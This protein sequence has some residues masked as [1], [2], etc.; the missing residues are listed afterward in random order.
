MNDLIMHM[1]GTINYVDMLA[2]FLSN[3][4]LPAALN[5]IIGERVQVGFDLTTLLSNAGPNDFFG[6][7]MKLSNVFATR[8]EW[9]E[10][11]PGRWTVPGIS[12]LTIREDMR[13]AI[14]RGCRMIGLSNIHQFASIDI[15][16][17]HLGI[18]LGVI[19]PDR[20]PILWNIFTLGLN[21]WEEAKKY[22][23]PNIPYYKRDLKAAFYAVLNGGSASRDGVKRH[24]TKSHENQKVEVSPD[25]LEVIV[26]T[27]YT[28][29]FINEL[30][31][32]QEVFTSIRGGMYVPISP[33]RIFRYNDE[34][35]PRQEAPYKYASPFLQ[36]F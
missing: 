24:I 27:V 9:C 25:E 7:R 21:Q 31:S 26:D 20:A 16:G 5:A 10:N 1:T 12:Y 19:G 2:L 33:V 36:A 18:A 3:N 34:G 8:Y 22:F 35:F 32:F 14:L 17:C 6:K 11:N 28:H 29:P 23:P 13:Q 4:P 30:G 15:T